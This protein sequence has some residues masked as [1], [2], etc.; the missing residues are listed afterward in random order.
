MSEDVQD[1]IKNAEIA[2]DTKTKLLRR[3][4]FN[5]K[6]VAQD[7][8][9]DA[10]EQGPCWAALMEAAGYLGCRADE[11]DES[12]AERLIKEGGRERKE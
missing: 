3:E 9:P 8:A 6:Q 11:F 2:H 12:E 10:D 5:L 7:D 1:I 4:A